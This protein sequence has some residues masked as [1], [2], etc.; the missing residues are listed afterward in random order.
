VTT[1]RQLNPDAGTHAVTGDPRE[2][3]AAL[4][5]GQRSWDAQPY[6][7]RRY[8][9]RGQLFTRSDSAWLVTLTAA[10]Q[11]TVDAQIAWLA[12]VLA[13]R[14]MPRLLLERHLLVLHEELAAATPDRAAEHA[15]LVAAA[16]RLSLER[17]RWVDDALLAE[18]DARL[19]SDPAASPGGAAPVPHAGELIAAAVA[20]ERH[21]LTEA[22][23]GLLRWLASPDHFDPVWCQSVEATVALVRGRVGEPGRTSPPGASEPG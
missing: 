4:R 2:L 20:D 21:G 17:Q 13:S 5:A 18:M 6:Y 7:E 3:Q 10:D 1:A 14:G 12:R 8:G 22:V 9:G 11:D 23:P 15:R 16:E 19:A